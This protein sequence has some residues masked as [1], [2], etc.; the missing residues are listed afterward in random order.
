[1]NQSPKYLIAF[2]LISAI[3]I[4]H[5]QTSSSEYLLRKTTSIAGSSENFTANNVNYTIQQSIGQPSAIGT[6]SYNNYSV[7]QGFIQPSNLLANTSLNIELITSNL[8]GKVHPNPFDESITLSFS[9]DIEGDINIEV[10]DL[11]GRLV[12]S[13]KQPAEQSLQLEFKNLPAATYILKVRVNKRQFIKKI[14]KK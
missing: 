14:I 5:S 8:K 3:Q 9:N 12:F 7:L 10:Y 11:I 13:K 6:F 1:M 4:T 2:L